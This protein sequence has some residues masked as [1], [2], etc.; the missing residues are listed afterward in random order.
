MHTIRFFFI[1]DL[2]KWIKNWFFWQCGKL[3]L[4]DWEYGLAFW[5]YLYVQ[6]AYFIAQA[7]FSFLLNFV[8][9][10]NVDSNYMKRV[11]NMALFSLQN[12][13]KKKKYFENLRFAINLNEWMHFRGWNVYWFEVII[14]LGESWCIFIFILFADNI[15]W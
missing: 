1:F 2:F 11:Q 6:N 12:Q 9:C 14:Y 3:I 10:V 7:F 15:L 13:S 5:V 8:L 4:W